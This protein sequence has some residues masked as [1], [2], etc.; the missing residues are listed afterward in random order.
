MLPNVY[1]EEIRVKLLVDE[2]VREPRERRLARAA[3]KDLGVNR[4]AGAAQPRPLGRMRA[5][6]ALVASFRG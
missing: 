4:R 1:A 2:L 6:I 3:R 5:L